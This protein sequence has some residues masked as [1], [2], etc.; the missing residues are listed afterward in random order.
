[1]KQ[2][3]G[4]F[5]QESDYGHEFGTL[6]KVLRVSKQ[7]K[8]NTIVALLPGW[9]RT[10][11]TR[12]ESG[13]LPP[14]FDQL[15]AIYRAFQLAGISFTLEARQQ[16]LDFARTQIEKKKTHRDKHSD[17]EWAKLRYQLARLDGSALNGT[18]EQLP[19]KSYVVH[20]PL[21]A[22][23][24]HLIGREEW[25][26]HLLSLLTANEPKKLVIIR[27]PAGIG[28]SS[29]LNW[30]ATYLF[31]QRLTSYRVIL[32][33]FRSL[34]RVG[35]PEEAFEVFLGTL[36]TEFGLV[37][38]QTALLSWDERTR[39]VLEQLEK[40]ARPT[41]IL[42]DHCECILQESGLLAACW[43]RF[44]TKFLRSKHLTTL[45]IATKQWPGWYEG[46]QPFVA[47][48][49]LPPLSVDKGVLVLQHL[50]LE[51]VPVLLLQDIYARTGGIPLCLEWVAALVK[52]PLFA[53]DWEEFT[54]LTQDDERESQRTMIDAIHRLL[55]EPHLFGGSV[56]DELAP[57]LERILATQR[58][59]RRRMYCCKRS[60][61]PRCRLRNLLCKCY[62]RKVR[63]HSRNCVGR[64]YWSPI[65]IALNSFQW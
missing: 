26:D 4:T 15:Y 62:V 19:Q 43:E 18:N 2:Q 29:E 63:V 47:E 37:Q 60:P 40:G 6:L 65:L 14:R 49:P 41:V 5:V 21:L 45:V 7:V 34:E 39:Q 8:Q 1:M 61:S 13:E 22:E 20:R 9:S 57:F 48:L 33:D 58:S 54:S 64:R 52:Q 36:L 32:C 35:G 38:P 31:R 53:D 44:L 25:Q 3:Q 28:K 23:T 24:S 56:A 16:F 30:L 55:Q 46:E 42:L 59:L 17:S 12:L 50:G 51:H 27:G 11:Y 10:S